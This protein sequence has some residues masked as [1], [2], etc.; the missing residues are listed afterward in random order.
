[1]IERLLVNSMVLLVPFFVA[2]GFDSRQPKMLLAV[3]LLAALSLFQLYKGELG[4]VNKWLLGFFG[5]LFATI[6]CAPKLFLENGLEV[7]SYAYMFKVTTFM[8]IFLFGYLAL[9]E[10]FKKHG[11][12][13]VIN[14]ML[15]V[16]VVMAGYCILQFFGLD[17]FFKVKADIYQAGMSPIQKLM[18][19]DSPNHVGGTLGN[20]TIVSPFIAM[21]IPLAIK[22]K[23]WGFVATKIVSLIL[24]CSMVALVSLIVIA[25][26]YLAY[27][28]WKIALV[29]A[30]LFSATLGIGYVAKPSVRA[31]LN[32]NG[33]FGMW[34]KILK[35]VKQTKLSKLR[36]NYALTGHGVGSFKHI[37]STTRKNNFHQA[38]NEYLE[39]L[40]NHGILGLGL[41]LMYLFV[42]IKMNIPADKHLMASFICICFC[43]VGTFVWH[44]APISLYT[45]IVKSIME[46]EREKIV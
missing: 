33:R 43:A 20:P 23:R 8:V 32:D 25:F 31:K 45:I 10:Y 12:D 39:I 16:G 44:I 4:K 17:Q 24:A 34:V 5:S 26:V 6:Y 15:F 9:K 13:E 22:R 21:L 42:F 3:G 36:G 37:F 35:D 41:L 18:R 7:Y 11:S 30:L 19:F 46:V 27:T 40:F 28:N 1:M 38:H 29:V 14:L 2:R